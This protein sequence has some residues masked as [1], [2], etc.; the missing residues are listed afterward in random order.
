MNNNMEGTIPLDRRCTILKYE[1]AGI[2]FIDKAVGVLSHPNKE[3]KKGKTARTIL[4]AEYFFDEECYRWENS[5]GELQNIYLTHRLDSPTSGIMVACEDYQVSVHLKKLFKERL[6]KK[7]YYAL[8]RPKGRIKDGIWKDNLKESRESG[9]IRVSR[10]NGP[11]AVTRVF[12][13]RKA[14]G[15]YGL[16]MLRMEPLTGRTHQLRVQCA[17]RGIPI[18]GDKSYGDFSFNRKLSRASKTD[19]LCLHAAE[20]EFELKTEKINK[21]FFSDSPLPRAMG[22]LMV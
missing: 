22:K 1:E 6:V 13:E 9:K 11:E 12:T 19:R 3:S 10:G 16:A 8:V 17:L 18:I 14:F 4:N 21:Q 5:S 20:I 2:W 15:K 7:T